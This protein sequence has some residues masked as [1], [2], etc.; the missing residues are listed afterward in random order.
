[1][2][3]EPEHPDVP[4]ATLMSGALFAQAQI[5]GVVE[6]DFFDWV[7]EV[8]GG[9]RFVKSLARRLAR[10]AWDKV[11]HDVMK[12]LYESV[13]SPETRHQLGEYYTPDWLAEEMIDAS[14]ADPLNQRVLDASCG[15]GT[16]VFHAVRRHLDAADAAGMGNAAAILSATERVLGV[17]VH[18]VAVTL[19]RVTYLLAIGTTRL[20]APDRPS[21][22]VPIYLGDSLQWGQETTLLTSEGLSI[23][24]AD[25]LQFFSE[26]LDFPD[27]VVANAGLFDQ[28]V[29][30]L[31]DKAASRTANSPAPSLSA[32]FRRLGIHDD[33]QP[34]LER[35]FR[36]MCDLHDQGRDHIWGYYVRNLARPVWL[37]RADNRVDVLVGNPPWLS[38]RYMTGSMQKAFR[39]MSVDR[40]MWAGASVATNQDL[41]ALFVE[42]CVELYLRSGG[43]F[44]YVMPLAVLSRRQ[45][46]GFRTGAFRGPVQHV[47]VA[48]DRP[49]DLHLIKPSFFPVPASVVFGRRNDSADVEVEVVPLDQAAETWSGRFMTLRAS[50]TQAEPHITRTVGQDT[51]TSVS[52]SPYAARF[53]QGA[54]VTPRLLYLVEPDQSA[55]LGA[56]AGRVAVRSRRSAFEKRPWKLLPA[57]RGAVERQFVRRLLVGE[58]LLPFRVVDAPLA[59]VP[60]D[61]TQLLDG[62]T[63]RIDGYPGL[64]EWW[65]RNEAIWQTHRSSERMSLLERLDFRRGLTNQ[66]PASTHRVV[67]T[68]SG[69]YLAATVVSDTQAV[70]EHALYWGAATSLDEARFLTAVLNSTTLTTMLRPKQARGEHNPRHYDKYVWQVPI[71]LF[72]PS[73]HIHHELA[74]AAEVAEA[75]VADVDLP[76]VSFQA[77]RRRVRQALVADGVA[78][79]IDSLVKELLSSGA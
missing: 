2:G 35:T 41:S 5:G 39:A 26:R 43:T 76:P 34:I 63:D 14:V 32:T 67:Y 53:S 12:V 15:S 59:V 70:V 48:F 36:H 66:F 11:E 54:T 10:F 68:A 29:S 8:P 28:L 75:V 7:V 62:S 21:F 65:R 9:D 33:D 31:A 27:R 73:V 42:R 3:F 60:W 24:T 25:D 77:L 4:A 74:C 55:P 46:N 17:D 57:N 6:A 23:P 79:T 44:A 69:M 72:D 71:P 56:G 47:T 51:P 38:Y 64:A 30:E 16:F 45:Y 58:A 49:W 22:S 20:C 37:S 52:R 78:A 61:G 1:M 40:G 13:I 19:A 18:P 50:K